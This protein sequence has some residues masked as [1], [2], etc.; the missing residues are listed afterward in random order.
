MKMNV[1]L[2]DFVRAFEVAGRGYQFTQAGFEALYNHLRDIERDT[3]EETVLDVVTLCCEWEELTP[4]EVV[5]EYGHLVERAE[6]EDP[7]VDDI[8]DALRGC[9][10]VIETRSGTYLVQVV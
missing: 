9:T 5:D 6:D 4:I 10:T 2:A 3:G 7:C 8:I 1:E